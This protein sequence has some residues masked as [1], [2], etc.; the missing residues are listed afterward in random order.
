MNVC[1]FSS[2]ICV[3]AQECSIL[4]H[5][6]HVISLFLGQF[7]TNESSTLASARSCHVTSGCPKYNTELY[8]FR[9]PK[10]SNLMLAGTNLLPAKYQF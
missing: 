10:G 9:E 7:L 3:R 5:D 2:S 1:M 8:I 6:C 4:R